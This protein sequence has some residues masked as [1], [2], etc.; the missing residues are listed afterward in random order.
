MK[1]LNSLDKYEKLAIN[2]MKKHG[3][4]D[5]GWSF[6][7]SNSRIA[8]GSCIDYEKVIKLSKILTRFRKYRDVK[9]TILHEIA[10][11]LVGNY[12]AHNHIWRNKAIEIGCNGNVYGEDINDYSKISKYVGKCSCDTHYANRIKN[13]MNYRCKSCAEVFRFV[14]NQKAMV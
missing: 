3:L 6:K 10:H 9:D 7:W 2:L 14:I 8:Y 1:N 12:N 4:I 5:N 13:N 11:A